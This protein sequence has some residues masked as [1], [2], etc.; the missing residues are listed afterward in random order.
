METSESVPSSKRVVGVF[1]KKVLLEKKLEEV[2][3]EDIWD[4]M[5]EAD[6]RARGKALRQ[7]QALDLRHSEKVRV[8]GMAEVEKESGGER[9]RRN[10]GR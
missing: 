7:K 1:T 5:F 8:M 4:G 10:G 2:E 6:R 9:V 3:D